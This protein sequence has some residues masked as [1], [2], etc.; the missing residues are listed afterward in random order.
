M[1]VDHDRLFKGCNNYPKCKF[2]QSIG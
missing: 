2:T 1:A